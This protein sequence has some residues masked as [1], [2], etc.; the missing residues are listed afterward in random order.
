MVNTYFLPIVGNEIYTQN[1][2]VWGFCLMETA[3]YLSRRSDMYFATVVSLKIDLAW[4]LIDPFRFLIQF[5]IN[6]FT[7]LFS[8]RVSMSSVLAFSQ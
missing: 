5:C 7:A 8:E 4:I 2:V 6:N 3:T 1:D